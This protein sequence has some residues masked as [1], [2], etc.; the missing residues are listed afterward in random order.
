M[1][2]RTFALSLL[3]LSAVV[4]LVCMCST[5]LAGGSSDSG[6]ARVAA[7]IYKADGGRAAGA[8]VIVCTREFTSDVLNDSVRAKGLFPFK[9]ATDD[10]GRFV[11]DSIADGSYSIEVNDTVSGAVLLKTTLSQRDSMVSIK[12]TL[13][14]FAGI[15]GNLG[16]MQNSSVRRLLMVY[17][18][19]RSVPVDSDGHFSLSKLPAGTFRFKVD[20]ENTALAP[21]DLD[22]ETIYTGKILSVPFIG[23]KHHARILL[24]TTSSGADVPGNIYGF[25]VLIRLTNTNFNF[26]EVAD[27]GSDCIFSK[28][29]NTA[30]S[31]EMER[32]DEEQRKAEIWIKI[33]T[34]FG[35]N[36]SQFFYMHWGNPTA[37]PFSKTKAV[38][39]TAAGFQGVWHLGD[40]AID[41]AKDAT[42]NR[43]NGTPS[44]MNAGSVVDGMIGKARFFDGISAAIPIPNSASGKLNFPEDGFYS[45]SAWVY[46]DTV[47][48]KYHVIVSKGDEQYF[49]CSIAKPSN[50]ALWNFDEYNNIKGWETC[51]WPVSGKEWTYIVG[52][53]KGPNHCLYINGELVDS[54][55]EL[56]PSTKPRNEAKGVAIGKFIE[57]D[58]TS[59]GYI[60][61]GKIDEVRI[62]NISL[63]ADWIKLCYMNQRSDDKMVTIKS[64]E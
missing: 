29:D 59:D 7:V 64:G 35:N 26:Q 45:L 62:N 63:G 8:R 46:S 28:S 18:L 2:Y 61:N 14:P 17:G 16:H 60:F 9:T 5:P 36:Q 43:F 53:R 13:R 15:D 38:F 41:S 22:S 51:A 47:Q 54:T 49:L 44:G 12:D 50:P 33:D 37:T 25:P 57:T 58:S 48:N 39:D 6:N 56:V 21:V 4:C 1:K 24:N 55:M 52:V 32:W 19:D 20:F 3:F 30:L 27:D 42:E 31:F 40:V 23:W 10:S 11:I 34:I